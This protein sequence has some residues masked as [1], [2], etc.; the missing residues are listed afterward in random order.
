MVKLFILIKRKGSNRFIGAIPTKKGATKANLTKKLRKQLKTGF[1]AKI[2]NSIQLKKVI[3]KMR[4]RK[5][6]KRVK[7]IRRTKQRRKKRR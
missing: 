1:S 6:A 2:V 5:T 7:R 4:P 3:S